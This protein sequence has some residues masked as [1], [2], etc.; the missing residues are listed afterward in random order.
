MASLCLNA[1]FEDAGFAPGLIRLLRHETRQHGITPYAL[2]RDDPSRFDDYQRVQK[3]SRRGW[4][5]SPYWASF[6]GTPDG[7]TMF[8]GMYRAA[9]EGPVPAGWLDPISL[10]DAAAL[11]EYDLYALEPVEPLITYSGRLIVDWG[12]GT[13]T[14]SQRAINQDKPIV[15]LRERFIEPGFP[16]YYE[17]VCQVSEL[18]SLPIGWREALAAARGV[19]LLTCPRTREQYVGC[20]SG[21]DGFLGRWNQYLSDGTGGNIG[22][23][24]RDPADYR[25][26]ILQVAGS[27]DNRDA[28]LSMEAIWKAKLQSREM[29]LNRN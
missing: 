25:I 26:S 28:I 7:K 2:W 21:I 8:V 27:A 1:L 4:F 18:H 9:I 15:E 29:G 14:W 13:R 19:Y 3:Q 24:L 12:S 22:L 5:N 6:V 10:R 23:K 16:G 20:A 11:R 17:F